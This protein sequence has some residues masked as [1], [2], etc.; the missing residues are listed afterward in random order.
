L[1]LAGGYYGVSPYIS[2]ELMRRAGQGGDYATVTEYVDFPALRENLKGQ[3]NASFMEMASKSDNALA[4]GLALT[5]G[6]IFID[7]MIDAYITP[8]GITAMLEGADAEEEQEAKKVK[9]EKVGANTDTE[10]ATITQGYAGGLNRFA[11]RVE[12]DDNTMTMVF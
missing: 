11:V 9:V 5:F 6:P 8:E 10:P 7:K 3:F 2:V 1:V 12:R 4:T